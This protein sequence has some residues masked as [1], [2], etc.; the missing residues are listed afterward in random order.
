MTILT[1]MKAKTTLFFGQ[2]RDA[3]DE[4]EGLANQLCKS[5]FMKSRPLR[6]IY[7]LMVQQNEFVLATISFRWLL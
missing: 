4:R 1:P 6:G 2:N 3:S 5:M 7:F